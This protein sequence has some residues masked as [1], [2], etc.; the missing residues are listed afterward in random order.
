MLNT[1]STTSL[2]ANDSP[3]PPPKPRP[4][5]TNKCIVATDIPPLDSRLALLNELCDL[6]SLLNVVVV[7]VVVVVV[8]VVVVVI[9][10]VVVDLVIVLVVVIVAS[11]CW[12]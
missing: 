2:D 1:S 4:S 3:R 10:G 7:V 8:G 11:C 5:K 12:N 6:V 9:V